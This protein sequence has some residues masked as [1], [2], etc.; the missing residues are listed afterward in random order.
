MIRL[1]LLISLLFIPSF[2]TPI[3]AAYTTEDLDWLSR[4][5]YYE[6]GNQSLAGKFAVALVVINRRAS[7]KF[8]N[9]IKGIVTQEK[10]VDGKR[11]CQFAW[12][13]TKVSR[14]YVGTAW[15]QSV[16]VARAVLGG[17]VI[18][19]TDGATHYHTLK[20]HPNW[21]FQKLMVIDNHVFYKQK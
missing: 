8:P 17:N 4:T 12:Y 2:S 3:P 9:D 5:I 15:F 6:A 7:G 18:D 10:L 20:V 21:G 1:L 13:C 16:A 14:P 11:Q 19:F